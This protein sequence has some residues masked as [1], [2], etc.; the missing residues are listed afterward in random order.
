M[1]DAMYAPVATRF[2]TYDVKID[3]KCQE[4]CARILDLPLMQQWMAAAREEPQD[5]DEFEVEF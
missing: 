4:Y 3:R 5:I 1:A 2:K